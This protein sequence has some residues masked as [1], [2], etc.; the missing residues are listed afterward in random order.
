[1]EYCYKCK[2][3]IP[4]GDVPGCKFSDKDKVDGRYNFC[5]IERYGLNKCNNY[6]EEI[7]KF[8]LFFNL[9]FK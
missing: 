8:K 1:M 9:L 5:S 2:G 6:K 4:N 7:N 3:F